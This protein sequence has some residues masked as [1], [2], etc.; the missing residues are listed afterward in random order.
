MNFFSL[1]AG[2]GIKFLR[3]VTGASVASVTAGFRPAEQRRTM[4]ARQN[5][6]FARN[7]AHDIKG[8]ASRRL[9]W[10]KIKPRTPSFGYSKTRR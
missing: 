2:V 9:P 8:A 5:A 3:V 7:R 1:R 10:F 6:D 4:G